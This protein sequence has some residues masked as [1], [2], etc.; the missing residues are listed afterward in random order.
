M[1]G[2]ELQ[3]HKADHHR[4]QQSSLRQPT[5]NHSGFEHREPAV[6]D[7]AASQGRHNQASNQRKQQ[8][9]RESITNDA[10]RAPNWHSVQMAKKEPAEKHGDGQIDDRGAN[11]LLNK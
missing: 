6:A 11:A 4:A 10:L 7:A 5:V 9:R 2:D 8:R 1:I 3:A